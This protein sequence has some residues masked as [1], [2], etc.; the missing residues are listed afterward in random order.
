[1][2]ISPVITR[3]YHVYLFKNF[4]EEIE[5]KGHEVLTFSMKND[6]TDDLLKNLKIP[7]KKYGQH[8]SYPLSEI[9]GPFYDRCSLLNKINGFDPDLLL[10]VNNLPLAPLSSLLDTPAVVFLELKPN[11]KN[12][13][14]IFNHASKIVTPDC[15]HSDIPKE[16]HLSHAS[17]H[18]LAYLHPNRFTP[19]DEFL[20]K[21]DLGS[22]DYVMV[23][24]SKR[25]SHDLDMKRPKLQRREMIDLVRTLDNHCR[26][27]IDDRGRVPE[28]LKEYEPSI[29]YHK[30]LDLM[31]KSEL[32]IGDN[33]ITSSEAGV[34]GIPW[35]YISDSLPYTLE[36]QEVHYEIGTHVHDVEDGE[37][38]AEMIL[39][40]E[41]EPDLETSRK[42]ILKDKTDLTSWMLTL[43]QAMK[44]F[45]YIK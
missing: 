4:I 25:T 36:D 30:Y 35:I 20:D 15:Y 29:P 38:L 33:P 7:N 24:F 13:H 6:L 8:L 9:I 23:S 45:N 3:P 44:K 14:L 37:E 22:E 43:V 31:A 10:S 2:R 39:T 26:V 32:V 34:L 17:Y 5:K 28:P 12:E 18:S 27:F 41:I 42:K 40:G 11:R 19:D 16:K 21:M 1:M